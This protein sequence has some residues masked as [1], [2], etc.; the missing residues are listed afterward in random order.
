M[1]GWL[2]SLVE[3]GISLQGWQAGL[4]VVFGGVMVLLGL[5]VLFRKQIGVRRF[6]VFHY[7]SYIAFWLVLFH[8]IW[9]GS[10]TNLPL[11]CPTHRA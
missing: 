8:G 9:V 2:G 6:R 4:S 7:T 10:D 3:G 1:L 11:A 5:S